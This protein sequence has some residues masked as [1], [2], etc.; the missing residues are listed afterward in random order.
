M[1]LCLE[2]M[3]CYNQE[4]AS[5]RFV[6]KQKIS[7]HNLLLY[8]KYR[9]NVALNAEK[10]LV[11]VSALSWSK[12]QINL[13]Q[14]ETAHLTESTTAFSKRSTEGELPKLHQE[15]KRALMPSSWPLF[16]NKEKILAQTFGR[17]GCIFVDNDD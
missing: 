17:R 6:L 12:L 4:D 15:S 5:E 14:K 7:Q 13:E 16:S 10:V 2:R 3:S 11:T 8:R 1:L 9:K